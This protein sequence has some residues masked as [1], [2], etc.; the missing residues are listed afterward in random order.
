MSVP[1]Y[2][3]G[4][5]IAG[6]GGHGAYRD[7]NV[8]LF[9]PPGGNAIFAPRITS[10]NREILPSRPSAVA[11]SRSVDRNQMH[12]HAGI[13]KRAVNMVGANIRLQALPNWR[14]LGITPGEARELKFQIENEWALF[15]EDP[16][17]LNDSERHLM[18]G[19]QMLLGCRNAFGA[20]GE[21]GMISRFD[22]VRQREYRAR[23]ASFFEVFDTDRISTPS[24]MVDGYN[25]RSYGDYRATA[26]DQLMAGKVL[27][28]YGAYRGFFLQD[29]HPSE[30]NGEARWTYV[31][32]ETEWGRPVGIHWFPKHRAGAQR[33]MPAII[34]SLRNVKMLD[35]YD[36][37]TLQAAV[38]NA[39]LSIYIET[40]TSSEE[41]LKKLSA[42]RPGSSGGSLE[43][44][45]NFRFDYYDEANLNANGSRIPVLPFG[46]KINMSAVNRATGDDG[47]FRSAF[48]R[49]FA[50]I[51]GLSYEEFTGDYSETTF[52]GAR[53]ALISNYKLT[54]ADRYLY[55]HSTA[56][57]GYMAWLEEAFLTKRVTIKSSWPAFY[58]NWGA[59]A[60]CNWMG[61]GMGWVDPV[62]EVKAAALRVE[63][64]F[65]SRTQEAAIIG[66]DF[67]DVIDERQAE[68]EYAADKDVKFGPPPAQVDPD[69]EP[70]EPDLVTTEPAPRK[71]S[72]ETV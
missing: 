24:G 37:A 23:Y 55:C 45:W 5:T 22:A 38:V 16:R 62:N 66:N 41:M 14:A 21:V 54:T 70:D 56:S 10:P 64:G 18:F 34:S 60:S 48:N 40:D 44:Q 3:N 12:I 69:A 33:G 67:G 65:S 35:Q 49:A 28:R 19:G 27:D 46:D 68:E 32:R 53:Q 39:I 72:K 8:R 13:S 4:K 52:A 50:T 15:A 29:T 61:P 1:A 63:N 43:D 51:M 9:T 58:D 26:G 59:Y 42:K 7:A 30:V 31:P 20:D 25:P 47:S 2:Q 71:K 6:W 57:L 36:D 17:K 11:N